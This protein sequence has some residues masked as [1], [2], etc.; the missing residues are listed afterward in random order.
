MV[1]L[2][3]AGGRSERFW[4]LAEKNLLPFLG[5]PLLFHQVEKL[6]KAGLEK[7]VV[8]GSSE[9]FSLRKSLKELFGAKA[10]LQ[11]GE[12]QAAAVLSAREFLEKDS[13]LVVNAND[14]FEEKLLEEVKKK[15]RED[16]DGL[17]VGYQVKEYFP[18]GYLVVDGRGF[19]REVVEKPGE[20]R[21]PSKFVRLVVDY[22]KNGKEFCYFLKECGGS[23]DK[24]YEKALS[25]MAK[26]KRIKLI[27]YQG[28][29]GYLKYPWHT[30]G[31]MDL[32]LKT[33]KKSKIAESAKVSPR[34][35]IL[36]N[37]LI[38]DGASV[39]E[40]A[41]IVGPTY[42]G[43][44]TVV[45]NNAMVRESMIGKNCLIGFETEIARSFIGDNCWFH[46][47]Y[48]GDCVLA[49]NAALG[50]GAVLANLRLDGKE[51][52]SM[53]KG[54]KIGTGRK[55][56]G[57][58]IGENVRIGVNASVMPG[59]KIGKNSYVGS[60]VVLTSDLPEGKFCS[61]KQEQEIRDNITGS[62]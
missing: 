34:A 28:F 10:V 36:G 38:K 3:L 5:K 42:I 4:P 26:E 32:F 54:D 20:G 17:L 25:L 57:A 48:A 43:E 6:K 55:K 50:A 8:V 18:G 59:V 30:L 24:V 1:V 31:M 46:K 52:K 40:G 35:V 14:F 12:G 53:V 22:F 61:V 44:N 60:G 7:I 27:R 11:E 49:K 13:V 2:V 58:I 45:G 15:S 37:V 41:K 62:K 19:V 47:N 16:I 56:L 51:I 33:I 39:F 29:W 23:K 9:V 21:E